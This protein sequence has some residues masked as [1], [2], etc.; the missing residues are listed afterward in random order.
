MKNKRKTLLS[1]FIII[2]AV[3]AFIFV[4]KI[5][6]NPG[7]VD[8]VF[9]EYVRYETG[10]ISLSNGTNIP[11][12]LADTPRVRTRG[13]SN[14]TY[15]PEGEGMLFVFEESGVYSFWMKDM[16]FSIDMIWIDQSG[17]VVHVESDVAPETY[18]TLFTSTEPALYVLEVNAG[19]TAQKGIR[20]GSMLNFEI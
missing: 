19:F 20:V 3:V 10:N 1:I 13:L 17:K 15:L 12:Y 6:P 18:P 2:L 14:K 16:N 11:V 4:Q 8:E 7:V 5:E 9:S